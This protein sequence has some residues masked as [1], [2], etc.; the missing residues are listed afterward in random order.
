MLRGRTL[1]NDDG[2]TFAGVI[3]SDFDGLGHY[4]RQETEGNFPGS[5]IRG[6]FGNY[7]PA[8]GT[9]TINPVTG[10]GSD[11]S[12]YPASSAPPSTRTLKR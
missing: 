10:A 8:R 4:R 9:Y 1:Y 11:Y 7:N 5:N 6:Q 12:L 3:S 2:S